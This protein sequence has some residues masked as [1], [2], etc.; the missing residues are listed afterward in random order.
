MKKMFKKHHLFLKLILV[1]IDLF[2]SIYEVHYTLTN[3][4]FIEIDYSVPIF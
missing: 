2:N 3:G 4:L 1:L